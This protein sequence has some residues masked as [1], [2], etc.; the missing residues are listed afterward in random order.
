M[1]FELYDFS[2]RLALYLYDFVK[3]IV[4]LFTTA[5]CARISNF[6]NV[7][8]HFPDFCWT[9]EPAYLQSTTMVSLPLT[10]PSRTKWKTCSKRRLTSRASTVTHPDTLRSASCLKTHATGSTR[11]DSETSHIQ[12]LGPPPFTLLQLKAT[13]K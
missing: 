5:L 1:Y 9:T 3:K 11:S 2:V 8:F 7:S 6:C 4:Y 10:S 13:S 12:R